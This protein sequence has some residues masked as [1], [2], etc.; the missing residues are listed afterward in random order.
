MSGRTEGGEAAN[1]EQ[2][3]PSVSQRYRFNSQLVT[4]SPVSLSFPSFN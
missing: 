2:K 4:R 3:M 1:D